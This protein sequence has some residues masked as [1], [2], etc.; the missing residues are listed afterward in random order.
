MKPTIHSS[1]R[2]TL[3]PIVIAENGRRRHLEA[4]RI[5]GPELPGESL[6]EEQRDVA[7][8]DWPRVRPMRDYLR[9]AGALLQLVD[10]IDRGL[11]ERD[12]T[13]P[14]EAESRS[15]PTCM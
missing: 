9:V 1:R 7:G 13:C 6:I 8:V 10:S 3:L 4:R 2:E 11:A 5:I 12:I 15:K 14:P